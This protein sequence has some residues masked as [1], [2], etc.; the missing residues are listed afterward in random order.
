MEQRANAWWPVALR[1][2]LTSNKPLGVSCAGHEIT[3]FRDSSGAARAVEDRCPHR[4]VPLSLGKVIDGRIRCAYHGWTF[5]GSS[6]ACSAIPNLRSD[7]RVPP[8]YGVRV[9][10]TREIEG[11]VMVWVGDGAPLGEPSLRHIHP[12]GPAQSGTGVV[13]LAFDAY[14]A[15]LLDAPEKLMSF[16][17]VAISDF[18]LG[19]PALTNGSLTIDRGAAWG[20]PQTTPSRYVRDYPLILRVSVSINGGFADLLLLDQTE[21]PLAHL[22]IAASPGARGTTQLCWRGVVF[23][24]M[25]GVAPIAWH[26]RNAIAG[27][28]ID[29]ITSPDAALLAKTMI[30]PSR[31]W[32]ME[33][34]AGG[35]A[36]EFTLAE[37]E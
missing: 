3:L 20:A 23:P 28:S 21:T 26:L 36:A 11:F 8:R 35:A 24:T 16:P 6:G 27:A 30:G 33:Y 5:D 2:N 22:T 15:L 34:D 18:Y 10:E 1:E 14:R 32:R 31:E 4:R 13:A 37:V 9:H 12:T 29:V 17:G 25:G 19:N 7:E